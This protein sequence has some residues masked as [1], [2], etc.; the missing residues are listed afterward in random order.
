EKLETLQS[1]FNEYAE[2]YQFGVRAAGGGGGR[3]AGDPVERE[4]L[5]LARADVTRAYMAKFGEKPNKDW[6]SEKADELME[7][8]HD[9]LAKRAKAILRQREQ[10]ADQDATAQALGL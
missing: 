6:V 9:D 7:K 3:R 2:K 4:M 5:K 10:V 1:E 8:R